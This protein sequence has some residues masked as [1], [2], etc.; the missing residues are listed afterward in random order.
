MCRVRPLHTMQIDPPT[1]QLRNERCTCC[2][3]QADLIFSTCPTCGFVVL[4][5]SEVGTS[6]EISEHHAGAVLAGS[7]SAVCPKCGRSA[8]AEFRNS[9]SD[10][11]LALGFRP[12]D[13]GDYR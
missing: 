8:F 9:T 7:L 5:C 12:G 4:I 1:W 11:I 2:D 10:E 6:F 3:G 13:Y